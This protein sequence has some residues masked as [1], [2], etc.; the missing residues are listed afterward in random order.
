MAQPGEAARSCHQGL[1]KKREN[2][3][4][5]TATLSTAI[6]VLAVAAPRADEKKFDATKL[7]GTWTY[8]SAE[9]NGE[10]LDADHFKGQTVVITKDTITLKSDQTFVIKYDLDAAKSPVA[11]KLEITEGPQGKGSKSDAIIELSGDDLKI[12]YAAPGGSAPTKFEAGKDS[13]L[14]LFVLKRSK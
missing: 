13:N 3:M 6:L 7:V 8:V 12:C 14:H 2:K 9:K 4:R 5:V 11:A 10:K 1:R